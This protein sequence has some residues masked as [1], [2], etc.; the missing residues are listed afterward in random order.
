MV[1]G[2]HSSIAYLGAMAGWQTVDKAIAQAP[3]HAHIEALMRDEIEPTLE[4]L[5]GLD[6]AQY[7][8]NL[9]ARYANPALAHRT[10]QIA[11]DGS[12][13]LPQRLLGTVRDRLARNLPVGRMALGVAAWMHYLRGVDESGQS[14]AIDDP[15]AKALTDLYQRSIGRELNL[16]SVQAMLAYTP[17]FGDLEGNATLANTLLRALQSLQAQGVAG[18]LL[19]VN[20][21]EIN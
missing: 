13:K 7:R 20:R 6:L 8:S 15:H 19:A 2:T 14:Y 1:N 5:P 21:G 18:T 16:D 12:Q 4:D 3:L 10:Q 9:L 11:M 17:V